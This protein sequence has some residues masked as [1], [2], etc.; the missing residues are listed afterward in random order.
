MPP[1]PPVSYWPRSHVSADG[2]AV[3]QVGL[4]AGHGFKFATLTDPLF[5]ANWMV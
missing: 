2:S 1:S 3:M 4:G 5:V